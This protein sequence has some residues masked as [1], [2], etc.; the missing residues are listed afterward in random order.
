MAR[1]TLMHLHKW[2][3]DPRTLTIS[4]YKPEKRYHRRICTSCGADD[5]WFYYDGGG[6]LRRGTLT[7]AALDREIAAFGENRVRR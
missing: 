4:D 5:E 6:W 7:P 2:L 1:G 3:Y